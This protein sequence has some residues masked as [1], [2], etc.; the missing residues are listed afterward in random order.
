MIRVVGRDYVLPLILLFVV[1]ASAADILTDIRSGVGILH[2]IEEGVVLAAAA[3]G[4]L[5][6]I[7]GLRRQQ[8]EIQQLQSDL[9][10]SR[11][12]PLQAPPLAAA[13]HELGKVIVQ[14]FEQWHLSQSE[15]EIGQL[16][17]KGCSLKEIALLRGTG[18]K[19]V[20]QQASSIY[21]KAEVSGRHTFSAWFIED[22][23]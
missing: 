7:L 16:L 19:T 21:Q 6:L 1:L 23:L 4:L 17:L 2:V 22:L 5:F 9:Q 18:E 8:R 14:Q 13:R 12:I 10:A 20:R 3:L 15:R 11:S